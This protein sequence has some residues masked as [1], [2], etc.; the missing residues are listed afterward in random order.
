[1]IYRSSKIYQLALSKGLILPKGSMSRV[2]VYII[3]GSYRLYI[4]NK[5]RLDI[6]SAFT[7]KTNRPNTIITA[8]VN[9]YKQL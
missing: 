8:D 9:A 3:Q 2:T 6:F 7:Y 5:R 1:M 4:S